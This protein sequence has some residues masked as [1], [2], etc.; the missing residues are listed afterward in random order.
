[1]GKGK[2]IKKSESLVDLKSRISE[3]R[4][5]LVV[6]KSGLRN[7]II[8]LVLLFPIALV[9]QFFKD[10]KKTTPPPVELRT[11]GVTYNPEIG[12][13][14]STVNLPTIHVVQKGE[15]LWQ[16]AELYYYDGQMADTIAEENNLSNPNEIEI[17]MQLRI[18]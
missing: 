14:S 15:N 13:S 8:I 1:M 7:A 16:I 5:F 10:G 12:D 6:Y 3:I 2:R 9:G 18:E 11:V 17:G 4:D